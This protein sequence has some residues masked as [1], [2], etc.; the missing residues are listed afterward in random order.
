MGITKEQA[1][2]AL[3]DCLPEEVGNVLWNS[4]SEQTIKLSMER[5]MVLRNWKPD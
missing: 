1:E 2:V 4:Q 3:F 5:L